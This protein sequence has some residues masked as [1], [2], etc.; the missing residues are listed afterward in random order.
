[1]V[2]STCTPEAPVGIELEV[3][4]LGEQPLGSDTAEARAATRIGSLRIDH[5][6]HQ[7]TVGRVPL[8]LT[9]TEFRLLVVLAS[10]SGQVVPRDL[11]ARQVWGDPDTGTSRTIDVHVGRLRMKLG[12]ADRGA[13]HI[14]SVRGF[15]YKLVTPSGYDSTAPLPPQP[16]PA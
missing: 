13:P 16:L 15:G 3:L 4:L 1:M 7:V 6:S 8:Q 10:R 9:P 12:Q 14:V 11:L 2:T 5:T